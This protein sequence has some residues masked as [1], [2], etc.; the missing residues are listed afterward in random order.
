MQAELLET[1]DVQS[2]DKRGAA[3]ICATWTSAPASERERCRS[4][5]TAE[6]SA[7]HSEKVIQERSTAE[8]ALG[9]NGNRSGIKSRSRRLKL[10]AEVRWARSWL[11]ALSNSSGE[12][13]SSTPREIIN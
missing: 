2:G 8:N 3:P 5:A 12:R 13:V 11:M 6:S 1:S 4:L 10:S 9:T 7:A